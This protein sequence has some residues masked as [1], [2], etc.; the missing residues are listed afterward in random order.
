MKLTFEWNQPIPTVSKQIIDRDVLLFE[1]NEA[2]RLMDPYVPADK[3][4]LAQKVRVYVEGEH[5]VIHYLSP[6]AHYQYK[7]I[8]YAD[9][10]TGAAAFTNGEGRFWSRPNVAKVPTGKKLNHSTFRHPLATSEWDKA[11]MAARGEELT[12]SVENFI[13]R[14]S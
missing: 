10:V 3:L 4:I 14:K 12:E 11:M 13:R 6:Y 5:G 8:L 7:G 9:P 2:K 1:A